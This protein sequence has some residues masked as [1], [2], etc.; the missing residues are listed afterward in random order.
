LPD[1]LP[2][3]SA[4]TALPFDAFKLTPDERALLQENTVA[5]LEACAAE[6]GISV[7]FSGDYLRPAD[8][9]RTQW[10]GLFGTEDPEHA[11]QYGYHP[12]PGG[13]WAF[14]GGH[15]IKDATNLQM[16][17]VAGSSEHQ[18]ALQEAVIYGNGD[19][20]SEPVL[21]GLPEG[22]CWQEV[23]DRIDAALMTFVDYEV[24]LVNMTVADDRVVAAEASWSRCMGAAGY[25]FRAVDEPVSSFSL[26]EPSPMEIETA[27]AD[28]RCTESSGW[29]RVFYAVLA[30]YQ[31]QAIE[32]DRSQFE[33]ALAAERERF[34]AVSALQ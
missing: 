21:A 28:V 2:P 26:A 5:L 8:D 25:E 22:G 14:V 12:A 24:L 11:A 7:E 3:V 15:Y 4:S 10:G 17:P 31:R 9:S 33:A 34:D 20:D 29:A 27:V 32:R 16:Q 6:Y 1:P 19:E 30:D 23:A 18:V 13:V